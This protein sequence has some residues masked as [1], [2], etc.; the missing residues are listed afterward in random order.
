[1]SQ[2]RLLRIPESELQ[3]SSARAGGPGGQNVNKVETKVTVLFD[4]WA[5]RTLTTEE[6]ER[7]SRNTAIVGR[8]D[9][10]GRVAISSQEHRTQSLNKKATIEKLHELLTVALRRQKRR[11]PTKKT[12]ASERER[13]AAKRIRSETKGGR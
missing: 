6:K 4:Y 5:S 7:L 8:L 1:M 12:R 3:F 11:I 9:A 10:Q 13:L 2:H